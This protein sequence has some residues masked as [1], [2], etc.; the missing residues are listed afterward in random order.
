M[1]TSFGEDGAGEMYIVSRGGRV[2]KIVPDAPIAG[3]TSYGTGTPGCAGIQRV[4]GNA[5]PVVG[6]ATFQGDTITGKMQS[7][8]EY[9]VHN[10]ETDNTLLIGLLDEKGVEIKS[11]PPEKHGFFMQLFISSFPILLLIAVWVYF[12]RQMQG[13]GGGRGAMSFARAMYLAELALDF[14]RQRLRPGGAMVTKVFQGEGFDS[15][16]KEARSSFGDVSVRKPKAS[17]PRSR[18]VYMLARNYRMV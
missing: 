7:G 12:M 16:V 15:F 9:V 2:F 3:L 11:E 4:T 8:K 17:R 14:A 5:S 10:P 13:A 6:S 18:E 1:I